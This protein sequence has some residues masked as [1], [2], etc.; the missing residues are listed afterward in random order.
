MNIKGI[1]TSGVAAAGDIGRLDECS[2][3]SGELGG[4]IGRFWTKIATS[5]GFDGAYGRR[6]QP[7]GDSGRGPFLLIAGNSNPGR[8]LN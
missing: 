1:H 6:T 2:C 5:M 8:A 3:S 7:D 4:D